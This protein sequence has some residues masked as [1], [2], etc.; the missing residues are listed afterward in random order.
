MRKIYYLLFFLILLGSLFGTTKALAQ[1]I[2]CVSPPSEVPFMGRISGECDANADFGFG[3]CVGGR[4]KTS[5]SVNYMRWPSRAIKNYQEF[6]CD[7]SSCH[8]SFTSDPFDEVGLWAIEFCA[9]R[10]CLYGSYVDIRDDHCLPYYFVHVLP[11]VCGDGVINQPD[12]E[13]D[14]G[15]TVS[16]DG[17]DDTCHLEGPVGPPPSQV[18]PTGYENP[19]L[20]NTVLEFLLYALR[21]IFG[22]G[23][24]LA[25]LMIIFGS[26]LV[27]TSGGDPI[28][29]NKGKRVIILAIIGLGIAVFAQG[30]FMLVKIILGIKNP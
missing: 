16:G 15:N 2:H 23:L 26:F 21:F 30:I 19:L 25:I 12:E 5:V 13:C 9:T 1:Q 11:P 27:T 29:A 3:T 14:D 24:G 28:K 4:I 17:C 20:W 6:S 18:P 8:P 7:S 10:E 22:L